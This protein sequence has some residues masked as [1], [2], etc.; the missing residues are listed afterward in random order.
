MKTKLSGAKLIAVI[1][2]AV[3]GGA[4]GIGYFKQSSALSDAAAEVKG[5]K[6]EV[7]S[8]E[9]IE[10]LRPKPGDIIYGDMNAL[11]TIIEYASLSCSHCAHFYETVMPDLQK[12]FIR[13][14]KVKLV[15][16]HFPLNEPAIKGA[17]LVECAGQNNL[18]RTNFI[19][20]LF[21]MQNKWAYDDKF[22]AN[23]KQIAAV[24]GIDSAAFDSC[25]NDKAL[26]TKILSSRKDAADKLG[27]NGTPAF[28]INGVRYDG[29]RTIEGFRTAIAAPPSVP[30]IDAA[31][32]PAAEPAVKPAAE[33]V[34]KP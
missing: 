27:V 5:S 18:E 19:K 34:A 21:D 3:V 14:G 33:P 29:E 13:T 2:I 15:F 24:G 20:V 9:G 7:V 26:E 31:E 23:L 28:Y 6:P 22:L 30:A 17:E 32:K 12:E 8:K 10:V 11:V 16:R 4:A 1:L 25:V